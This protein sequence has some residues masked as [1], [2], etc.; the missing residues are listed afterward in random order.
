MYTNMKKVI[1]WKLVVEKLVDGEIVR[2]E[3]SYCGIVYNENQIRK[4][5]KDF[6][7][8]GSVTGVYIIKKTE[9]TKIKE[10]IVT[11]FTF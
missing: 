10:E 3:Y 8:Q 2:T 1:E 11:S 6:G 7:E 5:A 9:V 4:M